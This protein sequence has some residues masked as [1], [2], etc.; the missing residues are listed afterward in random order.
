MVLVE[1]VVGQVDVGVIEILLGGGLVILSA[2][3]SQAL[4][5][6]VANVRVDRRDE[7]V[8]SEIELLVLQQQRFIDVGLH[9]PLL[10]SNFR[11]FRHLFD[12]NYAVPL[13]A[14]RR[15]RNENPSL[16]DLLF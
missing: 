8:Q 9:D 16:A 3:A 2:E 11:N 15:L 14:G 6:Q 5:V 10:G 7:H 12:Q 4:L 13:T 1:T